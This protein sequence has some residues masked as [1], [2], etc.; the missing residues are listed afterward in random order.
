MLIR[1]YYV[2]VVML[3]ASSSVDAFDHGIPPR[4]VSRILEQT[5]FRLVRRTSEIPVK[6][7]VAA[8]FLP[9]NR[10]LNT[11][12]VDPGQP[13]QSGTHTDIDP[14]RPERQLIFAALSAEYIV[15]Y[16]WRGDWPADVRYMMVIRCDG[17]KAK[18]VFYCTVDGKA[19]TLADI[20][21]LL[22]KQ[23]VSVLGVSER[24]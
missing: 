1:P 11:F 16:F 2:A 22:N 10:A 3:L 6:P 17:S 24:I 14:D 4:Q 5:K 8:K 12:L 9:E 21:R 19:N 20:Q 7:L 13:F 23:Q 18:Q 15:L